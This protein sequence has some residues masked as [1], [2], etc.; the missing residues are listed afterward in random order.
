MKVGRFVTSLALVLA[1]AGSTLAQQAPP[2]SPKEY[3]QEFLVAGSWFHGVH[4]LAFNKDDQL[5]AGSVVGQTLYRVQVDAGEVDRV[6]DPPTGMADDIAFADDGTM[7]WTAFLLGKVYIRRP[8]GK[9]IEV[10]NGMGGPNSLAFGKDGRLF[11]SEVFLGDALYEIDLKNVDKPDFKPFPRSELRRI[12]EKM[13]GLNGFE[14]HKDDGFLYGPLWFKGQVVKINLETG[15]IEVIAEGFKIPAAANIDPQNRDNVYVVDTGTGGIWS[16]SLSSKTKKLVASMKPG[17]DNLAFDSRGRLFVTSMTDNGIY[18]VDKQTGAHKT[19]VEGKLAVPADLAVT[20][21]GGKET[22]HVAD[23]FSYRT[24]DGQTGA[25]ADVIRVHGETHAYPL[26]LSI[27][28]RHTLLTSWF[29]NTV[30]K[31]DRKTGKPV[32]TLGDFAAP[33]DALEA[34]DGTL[35]VAELASAN[36]VKVSPDGKTRSTVVKE[37]R[38][39]AAMAQGPGN[40]IYVTEIAAGAVTEID[41]ATGVRRVV[42][43]GLAGPEGIDMGPDGRL[44]VAEV[45]QKRVVAIDRATGAKTVIASNLDIGLPPYPG[46]PPALIPTGVAVGRSGTV[47]VSSDIR[48]ALYKLTPPAP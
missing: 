16:V 31:V 6:I 21:E 28:P 29:S 45:G 14:I 38:G 34:V 9:T 41:V 20:S 18:L 11:V 15:A 3:N 30:E 5:F 22:V 8:N 24:V 37:L 4:G 35:Y 48:N 40:L 36:L 10:A 33:V 12:A 1:V 2:A 17:L 39:P 27:G 32:A 46:G 26:G 47:Y 44:Y 43:D 23:V 19:I 42:A 7:A 13:G 25:V